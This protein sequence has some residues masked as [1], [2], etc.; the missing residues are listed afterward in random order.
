VALSR[1]IRPQGQHDASIV[2]ANTFVQ[3][4]KDLVRQ[5]KECDADE[6]IS[7]IIITGSQGVFSQGL[8][9]GELATIKSYGQVRACHSQSHRCGEGLDRLA[10][11]GSVPDGT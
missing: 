4:M 8:D 3:L 1:L 7:A 2:A 11:K 6:D 9:V 10:M 5:T